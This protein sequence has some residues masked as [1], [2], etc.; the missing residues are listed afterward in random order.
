[1]VPAARWP[2]REQLTLAS[3][4]VARLALLTLCTVMEGI[5]ATPDTP[6]AILTC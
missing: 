1:M 2:R 3:G 5:F 4:A 6:A